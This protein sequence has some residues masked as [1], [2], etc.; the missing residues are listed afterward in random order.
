MD[1]EGMRK[2]IPPS[3]LIIIVDT[4]VIQTA[5]SDAGLSLVSRHANRD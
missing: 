5:F 2:E 4:H 3:D 1:E